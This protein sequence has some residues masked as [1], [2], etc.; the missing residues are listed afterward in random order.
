MKVN[1]NMFF[2]FLISSFQNYLPFFGLQMDVKFLLAV[3]YVLESSINTVGWSESVEILI[4]SLLLRM[5]MFDTSDY[6]Y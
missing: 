3:C 5:Y 6:L 1:W 4:F 2:S